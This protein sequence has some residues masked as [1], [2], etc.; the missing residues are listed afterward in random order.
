MTKGNFPTEKFKNIET[1]FYY[2]DV[3]LLNKTLDLVKSETD[4]Y[5]YE[6]H[7]AM[8][9]NSNAKILRLIAQ[10][11]LGA[12]CVSGG[13]IKA[14]IEA[15][16]PASTIALHLSQSFRITSIMASCLVMGTKA[17]CAW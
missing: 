9:A 8:K 1:P 6:A 16:F 11:G 2:Y 10:K 4:K 14:A 5:G 15:G 7:Y 13:E 17:S 3:E 12:D